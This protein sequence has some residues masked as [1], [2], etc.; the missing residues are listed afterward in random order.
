MITNKPKTHPVSIQIVDDKPEN[1]ALLSTVLAQQGYEIRT[2]ISGDLA[3]KSVLA[4]PPDLI[5]LDIMMPG[6]S[7]YEVCQLLKANEDTHDIPVIFLSALGE[8][9]DKVKAFS[10]GGVDYITKP[11]QTDEVLARIETHLSLRKLQKQLEVQNRELDAFA[12]TVAHDLK[13]PLAIILGYTD[14]LHHGSIKM[15]PERLKLIGQATHES[16]QKAVNIIDTLLLLASVHKRQVEVKP[17]NMAEI[18]NQVQQRLKVMITEYQGEIIL[19]ESWP[20][21]LGHT[22]WVEEVWMNYLSNGLKYGGQP[23]HLELGATP[24]PDGMIRF[25]VQDNGAGLA[26]EVQTSLFA[27]FTRLNKVRVE[28][29]GLGLS[30]ARRIIDKL[31]GQ[32]GVESEVGQGSLFYFTLPAVKNE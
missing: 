4:Y 20:I 2:A 11:F 18:V 22:L 14:M 31:G 17:L 30:I 29:H 32:V 23:P 15:N 7:G 1:L 5:L 27:A 19:P 24:Q 26:P 6:M 12:H 13:E 25:W 3:L 8:V 9:L 10:V 21:P 16:A 28:G